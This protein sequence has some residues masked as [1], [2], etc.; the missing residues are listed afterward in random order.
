MPSVAHNE[1][2]VSMN[3]FVEVPELGRVQVTAR[4]QTGTEAARSLQA[5]VRALVAPTAPET[6]TRT[7]RLTALLAKGTLK[8]AQKGDMGLVERLHKAYILAVTGAV[9]GPDEDG[10]WYVSSQTE[11]DRAYRVQDHTCTC[12]DFKKHAL[13]GTAR[14][15][16][17]VLAQCVVE[18]ATAL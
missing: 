17:H 12:P 10:A 4:G 8:A 11:S 7:S 18:K 14:P 2:P 16:K 9:A 5:S 15:C 3:C 1:A 6:D 13:H